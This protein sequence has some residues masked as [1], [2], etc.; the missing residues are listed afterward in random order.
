[1]LNEHLGI[2]KP[3]S[4]ICIVIWRFFKQEKSY[5]TEKRRLFLRFSVHFFYFILVL[6]ADHL[7]TQFLRWSQLTVV[8]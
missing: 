7:S 1:M 6:I 2:K 8:H 4:T 3:P 5:L